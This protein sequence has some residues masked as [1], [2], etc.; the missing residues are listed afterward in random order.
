M[1]RD[2]QREIREII[3]RA[4]IVIFMKGNRLMPMCGFSSVAVRVFDLLDVPFETIDVL[5]DPEIREGIKAFSNWPTIPQVY[6]KGEFLG[7][8]DILREMYESGEL[9]PLVKNALAA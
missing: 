1:A 7:G 3:E 2:V 6:L 9:A 5:E 8:S 4:P